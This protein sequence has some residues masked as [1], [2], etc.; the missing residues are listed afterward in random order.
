MKKIFVVVS[1]LVITIPLWAQFVINSAVG[2]STEIYR[3]NIS[4]RDGEFVSES[5]NGFTSPTFSDT[6]FSLEYNWEDTAGF[7]LKLNAPTN[8]K[9][10]GDKKVFE[11]TYGWLQFGDNVRLEAGLLGRR[12]VNK[13]NNVL[14]EWSLGYVTAGGELIETDVL[15]HL[16]VDVSVGPVAIE[17]APVQELGI[18]FFNA[19]ED[20]TGTSAYTR[21]FHGAVRLSGSILDM[22]Q[23]TSVYS[24]Q[25][26]WKSESQKEPTDFQPDIISFGHR[27]AFFVDTS[28][29]QN[30]DLMLGYSGGLQQESRDGDSAS[31]SN[32]SNV[33]HG[34]DLRTGINLLDKIRVESHHNF[35]LGSNLNGIYEGMVWKDG[36]RQKS[37]STWN[38]VGVRYRV[39]DNMDF[40]LIA[41]N[42]YR[43]EYKDDSDQLYENIFQVKPS[44]KYFF[45]EKIFVKAG[46]TLEYKVS[47]DNKAG[48]KGT[49]YEDFIP[50]VPISFCIGF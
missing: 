15:S 18:D 38:S 16:V 35:T 49:K 34:I 43:L 37:F 26:S 40:D 23:L 19:N 50:S 28:L 30:F 36:V 13:V 29:L 17:V 45:N 10:W 33:Y 21:K 11:G 2:G 25:Y 46:V 31:V 20:S 14:D 9:D 3:G 22:I 1:M 44:V 5:Y 4:L 48:I 24:P 47:Q 8:L 12:K 6:N 27:Y 32:I 42:K 7:V 39:I 41:S